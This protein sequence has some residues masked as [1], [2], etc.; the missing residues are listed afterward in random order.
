MIYEINQTNNKSDLEQVKRIS[1]S[2]IGWLEKDLEDL[3]SKNIQE[4]FPEDQL[5]IIMQEKQLQE[6]AD[7][8]AL[9]EKGNLYIFELKRWGARQENLLQVLRYG[10]IF[11][12]YSYDK[13]NNLYMDYTNQNS[14]LQDSHYKYF[15]DSLAEALK[16]SDFNKIQN[17]IVITDGADLETLNAIKYWKDLGIKIESLPYRI[18]EVGNKYLFEF[19]KYNP[20]ND[21][22]LDINTSNHIVNTNIKYSNIQYKEMLNENKAAAY[23]DKKTTINKIQKG[24]EVFLY[25][26]GLGIIAYG[27]VKSN[28]K[29]KDIG[30]DKNEEY[31]VEIDYKWKIN[32][33]TE[34]EKAV[35]AWE[36]NSSLGINHSFRGTRFLISDQMAK[37]I[38]KISATKN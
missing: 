9:D 1:L 15:S 20:K 7:I 18:F 36:I 38:K 21:I 23:Y 5:M 14:N 12:Q 30:K 22:I 28:C 35:G 2:Q 19:N 24:D 25:Q 13:L 6:H 37:E 33:D 16:I 27:K 8:L 17:F 26:T 31:Y 29:M 4:L 3:I 32:P 34:K 11:G 10:Q